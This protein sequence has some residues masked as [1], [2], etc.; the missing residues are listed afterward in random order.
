MSPPRPSVAVPVTVDKTAAGYLKYLTSAIDVA[1][2]DW[3]NYAEA[4]ELSY[5]R[6]YA[7]NTKL[8]ESIQNDL[9]KIDE[10]DNLFM[11]LA[12]SFLTVG[13]AGGVAG[14]L[15]K[16][17]TG[18]MVDGKVRDFVEGALGESLV[19][20]GQEAGTKALIEPLSPSQRPEDV[21]K[22]SAISPLDY[23]TTLKESITFNLKLLRRIKHAAEFDPS[24]KA[25]SIAGQSVSLRS[26]NEINLSAKAAEQ[27]TLTI[28]NTPFMRDSPAATVDQVTLTRK[29]RLA[30]W[31]GWA[32]ARDVAYWGPTIEYWSQKKNFSTQATL[33]QVQWEPLRKELISLGVPP[34]LITTTVR[35]VPPMAQ[36]H[37]MGVPIPERVGLDMWAFMEFAKSD[38]AQTLIFNSLPTHKIGY[39]MARKAA[40]AKT[41]GISSASR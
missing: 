19:W 35:V 9:I 28:L 23:G 16:H 17:Y 7:S 32:Q 37:M 10:R 22:A 30:L 6:A 33:E 27:L 41:N 24:M 29:A 39:E 5:S 1:A 8:L 11:T 13:V 34:M 26:G 3:Q 4:A 18:K 38:F 40:S 21:F 15:A 36:A 20:A 25:A 2:A 12:L 14:A 31:I